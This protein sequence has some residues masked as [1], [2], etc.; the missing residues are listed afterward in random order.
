MPISWR[1]RKWHGE[2][3]DGALTDPERALI[4]ERA[5]TTGNG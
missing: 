5:Q 1:R 4:L 2:V 3:P